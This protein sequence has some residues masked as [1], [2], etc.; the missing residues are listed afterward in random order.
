MIIK[1]KLLDKLEYF[2]IQILNLFQSQF[3]IK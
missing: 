2:N 1:F 3:L